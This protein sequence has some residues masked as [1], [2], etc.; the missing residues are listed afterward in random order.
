[1]L[2]A[3]VVVLDARLGV[4]KTN[5]GIKGR[6]IVGVGRAGNPDI[7]DDVELIIGPN[8][9]PVNGYGLLA[10]AGGSTATCT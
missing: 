4:V 6:R 3:G 10:T 1:M 7:S 9:W 5:I 2:I 8:T